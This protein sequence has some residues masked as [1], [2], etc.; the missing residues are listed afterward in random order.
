MEYLKLTYLVPAAV[1]CTNSIHVTVSR[2]NTA[3]WPNKLLATDGH[4]VLPLGPRGWSG[5]LLSS[6]SQRSSLA[7]SCTLL[8]A[9]AIVEKGSI[10]DQHREK[11]EHSEHAENR[12]QIP[13]DKRESQPEAFPREQQQLPWDRR[14]PELQLSFHHT[15]Q[16]PKYFP[17]VLISLS[18]PISIHYCALRLLSVGI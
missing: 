4:P 15:R 2:C 11:P 6:C 1:L 5:P 17:S 8:L 9:S 13:M 10:W 16:R 3:A 12:D 14:S 18:C 7:C